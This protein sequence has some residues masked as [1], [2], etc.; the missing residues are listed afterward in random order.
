MK[1]AAVTWVGTR[2]A[3]NGPMVRLFK[4]VLGLRLEYERPDFA[5]FR[6]PNDDTVEVF[7]PSDTEHVYFDSGPV[8]GFFVED[9]VAA[10]EE[11]AAAGTVELIGPLRAWPGGTSSQHFRAPDGNVYELV[12]Q[13]PGENG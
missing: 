13:S 11:L 2:T 10:R 4:E 3:E 6:L 8:V 7:G 1:V 9:V 5:V 12:G